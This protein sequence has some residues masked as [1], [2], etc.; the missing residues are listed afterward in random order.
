MKKKLFIVLISF[1]FIFKSFSFERT[2]IHSYEPDYSLFPDTAYTKKYINQLKGK[3]KVKYCVQSNLIITKEEAKGYSCEQ[4]LKKLDQMGGLDKECYG[5]SYIDYR[6]G[7]R[8]AY[9]KKSLYN[10]NTG[11]LYVKDKTVGGLYLD[12]IIDTY[13]NKENIYAISAILNKRPDN[14]FVRAIKKREAEL[15][16]FLQETDEAINVYALIQS[17]SAPVKLKIFQKYVEG[18]VGGRVREI[19]NWFYRMLCNIQ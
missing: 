12:V 13:K 7:E 5:V 3:Y 11:V 18:A 2:I 6:T 15:F 9:F 14:F 17:S 1:C 10:K 16:V 8:K 4:I 19:Q